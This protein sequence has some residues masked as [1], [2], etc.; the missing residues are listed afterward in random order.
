MKTRLNDGTLM[1]QTIFSTLCVDNLPVPRS[2]AKTRTESEYC[3][4][5]SSVDRPRDNGHRAAR[6]DGGQA[7][8]EARSRRPGPPPSRISRHSPDSNLIDAQAAQPPS[9]QMNSDV[10]RIAQAER[11]RL[12]DKASRVL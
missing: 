12:K 2:S 10:M 1:R 7:L 8:D 6:D 11:L 3:N 4:L 5:I 9:V